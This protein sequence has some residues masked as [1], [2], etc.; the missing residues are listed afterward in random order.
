MKFWK[1]DASY[2]FKSHDAWFLTE[3]IRWGKFAARHRHQGA[4]RPGEPRGPLARG[5]Q[6]P[7]RRGGRYSGLDVARRRDVLR[8][9]GVRSGKPVRLSRQPCHQGRRPDRPAAPVS[10]P[11]PPSFLQQWSFDDAVRAH[12]GPSSKRPRPAKPAQ[13]RRFP[14]QAATPAFDL[15]GDRRQRCRSARAAGHRAS[16][17][18]CSSGRSPARRPARRCRR[19][20]WSGSRPAS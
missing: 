12:R 5:R 10:A 11:A 18:C 6:G 7:R 17:A 15:G 14:G 13:G 4:G 3:N 2:P 8:R 16:A 19:R 20:R 9:Q 1:D